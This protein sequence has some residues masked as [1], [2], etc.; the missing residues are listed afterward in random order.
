M[1]K[2]YLNFQS[3][4]DYQLNRDILDDFL[5]NFVIKSYP[6]ETKLKYM[7]FAK[8]FFHGQIAS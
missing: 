6:N 7:E 4:T 3:K 8:K 5:E 2:S 1:D